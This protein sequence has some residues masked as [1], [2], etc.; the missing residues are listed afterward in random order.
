MHL[1]G[2]KLLCPTVKMHL[3]ENTLYDLDLGVKLT[4]DVAKYPPN[5]MTYVPAKFEVATSNRLGEDAI[6]RKYFI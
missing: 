6:T 4:Y 2:L 3:Q 1:L 5:Q